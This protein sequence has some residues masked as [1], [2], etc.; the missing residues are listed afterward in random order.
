MIQIIAFFVVFKATIIM[1]FFLDAADNMP[2][3]ARV[4]GASLPQVGSSVEPT[5]VKVKHY[6]TLSEKSHIDWSY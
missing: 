2:K 5:A 6:F 3:A 1:A 4:R